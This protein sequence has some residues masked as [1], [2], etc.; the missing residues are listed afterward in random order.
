TKC[1]QSLRQFI[2]L[3]IFLR[4][5]RASTTDYSTISG[6]ENSVGRGTFFVTA[7]IRPSTFY[8][9]RRLYSI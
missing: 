7:I 2:F 1:R 3:C 8:K 5:S 6:G 4:D 9:I